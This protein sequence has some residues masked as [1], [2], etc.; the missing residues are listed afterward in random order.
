M[1]EYDMY[2]LINLMESECTPI[3][4]TMSIIQEMK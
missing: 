4:S 1:T 2:S 3:N